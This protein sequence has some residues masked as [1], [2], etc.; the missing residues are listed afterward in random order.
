MDKG[1]IIT[2]RERGPDGS[3]IRNPWRLCTVTKVEEVKML[4]KIMPIFATTSLFWTIH[5]QMLGYSVAQC[6]TLNRSIGS[7]DIPPASFNAFYIGSIVINLTLYDRIIV[8][9]WKQS[10]KG[11]QGTR[12]I[13]K[14]LD[15]TYKN[16]NQ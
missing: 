15:Q 4:I 14:L 1:A 9:F 6:F 16:Q 13:S 5:A 11:A 10:S 8:P 2:S 7:F 12:K 3:T